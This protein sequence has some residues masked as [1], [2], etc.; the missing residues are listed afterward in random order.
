MLA[1]YEGHNEWHDLVEEMLSVNQEAME[2]HPTAFAQWL[3]AVDFARGP[4]NEVAIIGDANHIQT[5]AL[6]HTL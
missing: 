4:V 2:S 6:V 5:K 3:C 1:A